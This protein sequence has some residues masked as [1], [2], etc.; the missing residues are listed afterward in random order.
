MNYS[1]EHDQE[2]AALQRIAR[3]MLAEAASLGSANAVGR[4]L[5]EEAERVLGALAR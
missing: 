1:D 4:E 3:L 2:R 5:G